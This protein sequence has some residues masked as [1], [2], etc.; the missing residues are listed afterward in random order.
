MAVLR[1]SGTPF[2]LKHGNWFHEASRQPL[3]WQWCGVWNV[4]KVLV[5]AGLVNNY[6]PPT[7]NPTSIHL[8]INIKWYVLI[9]GRWGHG[10]SGLQLVLLNACW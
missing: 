8:H 10:P 4:F 3:I 9:R 7:F 6:R 5:V 1:Q 2:K